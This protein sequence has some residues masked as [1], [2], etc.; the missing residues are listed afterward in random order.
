MG[1]NAVLQSEGF[2]SQAKVATLDAIPTGWAAD[3]SLSLGCIGGIGVGYL[4]PYSWVVPPSVDTYV[5][6]MWNRKTGAWVDDDLRSYKNPLF[7]DDGSAIYV[8]NKTQLR[9]IIGIL[10]KANQNRN[11]D[12]A[13]NVGMVDSKNEDVTALWGEFDPTGL[14]D[15]LQ[16]LPCF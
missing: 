13:L 6:G 10:E 9:Q 16:Y 3:L 1:L 8:S 15:A 2:D 7:T 14:Q 12:L 4:T 5:V 11:P